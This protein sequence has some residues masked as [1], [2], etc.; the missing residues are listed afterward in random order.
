MNDSTYL[1]PWSLLIID[2]D[3]HAVLIVPGEIN[4]VPDITLESRENSLP[5]TRYWSISNMQVT[6]YKQYTQLNHLCL[7]QPG[8]PW[9]TAVSLTYMVKDHDKNLICRVRVQQLL[10]S[11]GYDTAIE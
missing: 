4:G 8:D 3:G 9:N 2:I 6:I 7:K 1:W 11:E 5:D 10:I